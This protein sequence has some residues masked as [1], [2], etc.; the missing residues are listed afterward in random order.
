MKLSTFVHS[1][2]VTC[3]PLLEYLQQ[4]YDV[5][6]DRFTRTVISFP[7]LFKASWTTICASR[8]H[9]RRSSLSIFACRF[10][11]VVESNSSIANWQKNLRYFSGVDYVDI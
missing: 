3:D 5:L 11:S 2:F 7:R 4:N 8:F 10:K 1:R 6:Y 9:T